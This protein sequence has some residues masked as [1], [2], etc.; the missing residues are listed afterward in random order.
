MYF[1]VRF[2]DLNENTGTNQQKPHT[3]WWMVVDMGGALVSQHPC[4]DCPREYLPSQW[5]QPHR[6]HV[7]VCGQPDTPSWM[8][9]LGRVGRKMQKGRN[10]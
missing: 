9:M 4:S 3:P 1:N 2:L 7:T 5:A 6:G 8:S 10:D